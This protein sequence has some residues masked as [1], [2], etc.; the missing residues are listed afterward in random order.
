MLPQV[1]YQRAFDLLHAGQFAAAETDFATYVARYPASPVYPSALLGAAKSAVYAGHYDSALA[2]TDRYL[3][4][5]VAG[6]APLARL[7]RGHALLGRHAVEAALRE[8]DESYAATSDTALRSVIRTVV[9]GAV[10]R[11][12]IDEA[13]KVADGDL[14]PVLQAIVVRNAAGR[15]ERSGQRYEAARIYEQF[16]RR[17][18]GTAEAAQVAARQRELEHDLARTPRVAVLVPLSGSL[19]AYGQQLERGVQLAAKEYADSTGRQLELVIEDTE[20]SDVTATRVCQEVLAREPLAVIG[21]LTSAA[22]IGCIATTAPKRIPHVVPAATE[23]G[24][25]TLSETAVCLSPSLRASGR[26]LGTFAVQDLGLC[27]HVVIA[28]DDEYGHQIAAE[29]RRAVEAAGGYIWYET[30]YE[31][32]STDFGSNLRPFKASFLDTLSDTTWFIG[33]DSKRLDNEEV[34]VY[35]DAVF[36]PGEAADLILLLPQIRFYKI[37]GRLLGTDGFADDELMMRAGGNLDDAVF[38]SDRPLGSGLQAWQVFSSRYQRRYG[39]A[40][41]RMAGLGYDALRFLA[42]GL[43]DSITTRTGLGVYVRSVSEFRGATGTLRFN[44]RGEN[45]TVPIYYIREGQIATAIH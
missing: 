14:A 8:Y 24:L 21:P 42:G 18:A 17:H 16:V 22:A 19:S 3:A 34:T 4:L 36:T 26:S 25:A 6:G 33:P 1:L 37:A 9:E 13:T 20:S 35:P 2:R 23:P 7:Y 10:D 40:P 45:T 43:A 29:Y 5:G 28:P 27:S 15:L 44:S 39:V 32:G 41:E 11:L 30:F 12:S 31:P 38:V